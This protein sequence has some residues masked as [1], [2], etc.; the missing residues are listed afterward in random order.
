VKGL[1]AAVPTFA[2]ERFDAGAASDGA[3]SR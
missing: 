3:A 1:P 2:V